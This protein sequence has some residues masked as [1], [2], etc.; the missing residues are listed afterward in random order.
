[1]LRFR[2]HCVSALHCDRVLYHGSCGKLLALEAKHGRPAFNEDI[3]SASHL[4]EIL[5]RV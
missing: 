5:P 4:E 2:G 1:M 3:L